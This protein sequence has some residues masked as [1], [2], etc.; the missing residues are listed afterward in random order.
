MRKLLALF[1]VLFSSASMASIILPPP[2]PPTTT[3]LQAQ[4]KGQVV[5]S[6]NQLFRTLQSSYDKNFSAVWANPSLTPQQVFDAFGTD[7]AQLFVIAGA[8][9]T[10]LNTI[11][12]NTVVAAPPYNYTINSDGTVTVGAPISSAKKAK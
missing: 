3:Q 4:L 8:T 1:L 5:S 6:T 10:M 12:P 11:V 7:A 2:A 9:A